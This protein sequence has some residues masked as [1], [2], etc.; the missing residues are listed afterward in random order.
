MALAKR[1][2]TP[3]PAIH[4]MPCSIGALLTE[5]DGAERE[6]LQQMLDSPAW[7]STMIYDAVRD[8]GHHIG[9]QSIGRHRGRKCRCFRDAA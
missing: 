4:G 3:P 1:V 8:E 2:L 5:L 6:A 7:N 9:R